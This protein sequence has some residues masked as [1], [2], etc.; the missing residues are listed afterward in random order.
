MAEALEVHVTMPN[1]ETARALGRTLVEERL[2]ACVNVVPGV[3]SIYSW[4]GSIHEDGEVLCLIKTS[5]DRFEQLRARVLALHPYEVP[6]VL[7]FAVDD[8][9]R[10]YLDWLQR[11]TR[12]G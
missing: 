11:N 8:G 7:A 10:D 6:E 4:E 3:V 5:P 2:A 12:P 1:T 9:S